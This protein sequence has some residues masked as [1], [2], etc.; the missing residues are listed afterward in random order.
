MITIRSKLVVLFTKLTSGAFK[1]GLTNAGSVSDYFVQ[2]L[3]KIENARL[4]RLNTRQSVKN[5]AMAGISK[6]G[7]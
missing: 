2:T 6:Y 4:R 7:V 1:V 3:A 5:I